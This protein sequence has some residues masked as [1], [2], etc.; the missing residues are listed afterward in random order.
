MQTMD[1]ERTDEAMDD[2]SRQIG[3]LRKEMREGFRELR[4]EIKDVRAEI[5]G[6]R[7]EFNGRIES[8]HTAITT[9]WASTVAGFVALIV[10]FI[11]THS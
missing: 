11:V 1:R 4:A 8:V 2:V 9:L 6:V 7:A 3:E 5:G 10:A